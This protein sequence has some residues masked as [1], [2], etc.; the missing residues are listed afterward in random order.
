MVALVVA[1]ALHGC[2]ATGRTVSPDGG[3]GPQSCL[4]SQACDGLAVRDC[5]NGVLGTMIA[6]CMEEGACSRGRCM[7]VECAAADRARN[8]IEGCVFYTVEADNAA[9]DTAAPTSFLVSNP[10][11]EPA[12]VK[13]EQLGAE[14][15]W[16]SMAGQQ[17]TVAPAGA[18]RLAIARPPV[19]P[20]G[21]NPADGLRLVSDRPVTVAQ[22]ESDDTGESALSSGGTMLL[23]THV[24]GSHYLVTAYPQVA[25][26]AAVSPVG[27]PDG[28]GRLLI[29]GT[30]PRTNVT[31][32]PSAS[33]PMLVTGMPLAE[34]YSFVLGDGDVFQ[35][36]TGAELE[37]LT[38]TEISSDQPIA[39]FSGNI[40]T[41]YGRSAPGIHSPDMAHEQIPPI[42]SWSFEYVAA[43][44]PPQD[45]TC[46]TLL[47]QA[48]ASIWRLL[49]GGDQV[50]F[51]D[52]S[53]PD[54]AGPVPSSMTLGPGQAAEIVVPGDFFISASGPL[55]VTQGMDCEASLSLAISADQMLND[56][57]FAT[58]PNFD[59]MVAVARKQGE[60]VM[61][62]GTSLPVSMFSPAGN[63]YE[64]ARLRL[65]CTTSE[66]VC[67]HRLQGKFGMTMRGMD[68]L[69]S[70]ALTAPAWYGCHDS[71]D[72][73]CVQ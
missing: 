3:A 10:G 65:P 57:T 17:A 12:T 28:A 13:L 32:K 4:G 68:V 52:F 66:R 25:T 31:L 67:P 47:G 11:L 69:A 18:A 15:A 73:T 72:L 19:V 41:T 9:S 61:L 27:A 45:G 42:A 43:S 29:V 59:E 16:T 34:S 58:L 71:I 21:V 53:L 20:S 35:A 24:L 37:D 64:V 36:W 26:T 44:L 23:P 7:T 39:V 56:L 49:T 70:Y 38:G 62:D 40:V 46:D 22:I 63:G 2:G 60:E 8:S 5:R 33:A 1:L 14:G 6:D 55:L 30:Q 54:G 48:G 51:V 50:T